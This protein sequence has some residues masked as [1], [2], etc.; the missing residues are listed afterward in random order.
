[1][2]DRPDSRLLAGRRAVVTGG[3][4]AIGQ[5]IAH[6][7]AGHGASVV[8]ADLDG[9]AC[10]A[11]ARR[12]GDRYGVPCAGV[13]VD[14]TDR[15]SVARCAAT[16]E[17]V[18]GLCDLLVVNAGVLVLKPALEIATAEWQR[19]IDVNLTGAFH[20]ATVFA[21][22]MVERGQSGGVIFT[23]SLFGVR[24]GAGNAAYSASKFGVIGLAQSMAADLAGHG[25]RVN[26]V[27][28]GQISSPMLDDLFTR[29]AQSNG[30]SPDAERA[31]FEARI[32]LGRLGGTDEVADTFVYLAS[33]LSSYVTG[34]HLVVDGGWRVG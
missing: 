22:R 12:I 1:M 13:A 17:Q 27:C 29:R 15:D 2:S 20:T 23:S 32:P 25:I 19:V 21:A 11:A 6:R 4:G 16:A 10:A 7:F 24:G 14:V 28:P 31:D 18:I 34:Q 8:V 3:A 5:A 33:A 30:T 9:D 26:A